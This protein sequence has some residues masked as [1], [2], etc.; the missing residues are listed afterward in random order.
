[1]MMQLIRRKKALAIILGLSVL[2]LLVIW[3]I[4]TLRQQAG[5]SEYNSGVLEVR[6]YS[7]ELGVFRVLYSKLRD[8]NEANILLA[9]KSNLDV[10]SADGAAGDG[11]E[12]QVAGGGERGVMEIGDELEKNIEKVVATMRFKPLTQAPHDETAQGSYENEENDDTEERNEEN[13]DTEEHNEEK[14]SVENNLVFRPLQ[15]DIDSVSYP[16]VMAKPKSQSP[17]DIEDIQPRDHDSISILQ[18][19]KTTF[20][21]I[22]KLLLHNETESAE[23]LWAV[24]QNQHSVKKISQTTPAAVQPQISSARKTNKQFHVQSSMSWPLPQF[25]RRDIL[26]SQWVEDLK[27]YLRGITEWRQISVV[28]ANIEHQEVVLNWLI[29]AVTVA[30]L[31]LRNILVL[32]ISVK[33][34]EFLI[35]KKINSILVH[36]TSVMNKVGLK[37]ITSAFNQVWWQ[38]CNEDTFSGNIYLLP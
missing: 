24:A 7:G 8:V 35:S 27:Q 23:A 11:E 19:Q 5:S 3:D 12:A 26:Q 14:K 6:K 9:A 31:S 28:T 29:S 2:S 30:K 17:P 21:V 34:H 22:K 32:S 10:I 18:R 36:P 16:T 20:D 4:H 25:T 38:H 1:M 13:D 37:R 15:H 33:L